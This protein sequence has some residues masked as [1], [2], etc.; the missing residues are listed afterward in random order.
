MTIQSILAKR[1]GSFGPSPTVERLLAAAMQRRRI[2]SVGLIRVVDDAQ[3]RVCEQSRLVASGR[4][5]RPCGWR[6][7]NG[8][9]PYRVLHAAVQHSFA[10]DENDA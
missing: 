2:S 8:S 10:L 3:R 9:A 4:G 7:L 5:F 6:Q 1:S